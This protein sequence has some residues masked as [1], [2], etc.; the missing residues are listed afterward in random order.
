[1][2]SR[3]KDLFE[4]EAGSF[5]DTM[6]A[7]NGVAG[8]KV[9]E[10]QRQYNWKQEHLRRLLA[11]CLNGF[12]RLSTS[13]DPEYTF[14]GSIIL[15]TD[16]RSEPTFDGA[17]LIVVDGQQRLTSLILM[18]CALFQRIREHRDDILKLSV[19][20]QHWLNAEIDTQLRLL[21]QCAIGQLVGL[22]STY[23]Y[24]R[25]IRSNDLR[26]DSTAQADYRSPIGRFLRQFA[27]HATSQNPTFQPGPIDDEAPGSHVAPSY[28]RICQELDSYLYHP[29]SQSYED[30]A[31]EDI[32]V[33]A[34]TE[35]E[36]ASFLQLFRRRDI[37]PD[38]ST[39][40]RCASEISRSSE[41]AGLVRLVLFS[42]YVTQRVV[43]TRVEAQNQADAF[44][45]FDA[46]N[47]T[48]EPLTALETCKPLLI[49]FEDG[50][51]GYSG[52]QSQDHWESMEST[53]VEAYGEPAKQQIET[54]QMLT[55]FAL[56]FDGYKLPLDLTS[57]RRYLRERFRQAAAL[58]ADTARG[59]VR[60]LKEMSEFRSQYWDKTAIDSLGVGA[61]GPEES[62]S[63]KLCLRFI[64]DMNTSLAVPILAR[65]YSVH[66]DDDEE[67]TFLSATRAVTAFLALR[68]SVTGGTARI[69]SDFRR[70]MEKK[71]S[72]GGD[73]LCIGPRLSNRILSIESLRKELRDFLRE[74][75]IGVEDKVSWMAKAKEVEFGL[76]APRP[77]CRFLLLAAAH[78][79][80]PDETLPGLLTDTDVVEGADLDFFNHRNWV[81]QKY[82]TV[83]HI[84]P[85]TDPGQGW[86]RRIYA[87]AATRQRIG[88]LILLPEKENQSIGS[89]RWERKKKFYAALAAQSKSE[90]DALIEAAKSQGYRFGK[91]TQTLLQSQER[92]SML[93]HLVNVEQWTATLIERRTE[94]ILELAWDEM[95]PW[96]FDD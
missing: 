3:V 45:I 2:V 41:A 88:N 54:K 49:Q 42:S 21:H 43:L 26:G 23:P 36:R 92:L 95:S 78:N 28:E 83:E 17:S 52:S 16:N 58:N 50:R 70:L 20:A 86:E 4:A 6:M 59:F 84:A 13:A 12:H 1:M 81:G 89:S 39:R 24:P 32:S 69:D 10:Y 62:D 85:N 15:A 68:R 35:F 22:G 61:I 40:N 73:P 76:Q 18:A 34:K 33:V 57:Q 90:R 80:R 71:P 30:D 29:D 14:L 5:G 66:G 63:L 60:S 37:H 47:T 53:L 72:S 7:H 38:Q 55:T 75:R 64:A 27:D 56:Y 82:A 9:P 46:L 19:D 77:L 93:D 11:D 94:N 48:G 25:M 8:Y 91:K 74:P 87:R 65:Y 67:Q 31:D 79:A 96:L 51:D 44:D